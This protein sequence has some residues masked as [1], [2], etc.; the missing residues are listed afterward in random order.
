MAMTEIHVVSSQNSHLY[1]LELEQYFRCRHEVFVEECGWSDLRRPNGVER[2]QYDDEHAVYLLAIDDEEVVGGQ[3][4]YPTTRPHMLSEI[5]AHLSQW[6]IPQ[7]SDHLEVTRYCIVRRRRRSGRA[8]AQLLLAMQQYC[9]EH[10]VTA[11]TAVIE[12]AAA[13]RWLQ[14]GLKVRPLGLPQPVGGEP[15]LAVV[16]DITPEGYASMLRRLGSFP[17]NLVR[18]DLDGAIVGINQHAA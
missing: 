2:D 12:V 8:D 10:G 7:R 13:P 1:S 14:A 4:F 15:T 9:L 16:A 18:R 3:R 17:A 5:F 6:P 11:I